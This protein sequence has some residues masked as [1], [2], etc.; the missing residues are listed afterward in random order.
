MKSKINPKSKAQIMREMRERRSEQG[1][2]NITIW[3]KK[4]KVSEALALIKN[5][6]LPRS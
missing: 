6:L 4:G 5:Y 1:Y 3:I 2:V